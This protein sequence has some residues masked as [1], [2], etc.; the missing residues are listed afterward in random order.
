MVAPPPLR[1]LMMRVG[2]GPVARSEVPFTTFILD[3][4]DSALIWTMHVLA[5]RR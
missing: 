1:P 2:L 3:M 5:G 4:I